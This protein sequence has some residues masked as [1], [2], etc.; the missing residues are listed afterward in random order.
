MAQTITAYTAVLT[1]TDYVFDSPDTSSSKTQYSVGTDLR[2]PADYASRESNGFYP[3]TSP[4][5]GWVRYYL[6]GSI[7]P[8]YTTTTDKCKAPTSVTLNVSSKTLSISGGAGGDLNN[9]T[10]YGVS[11]RD[12]KIGTSSY[13]SWSSD[14]VVTGGTTAT[15][16]VSAPSGYVRQFRVRSLG[17]AGA[18]YYSDYV[19]CSA[20]LSGNTAPNA[21]TVIFPGNGKN[22]YSKTPVVKLNCASDPQG[23]EMTLYRNVDGAGWAIVQKL[24]SG[25]AFDH[26]P[27]V[28]VGSHSVKYKLADSYGLESGETTVSFTVLAL[29]W[30]RV[31]QTGTVIS[32]ASVSHQ[33]DINQLLTVT[34]AQCGW[35]GNSSVA[36]GGTVG[37]FS[38]WKAQMEQLESAIK[39]NAEKA[40]RGVT[41]QSPPSYPTASVI[42]EIRSQL[43]AF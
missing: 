21:P 39:A 31:I 24:N 4:E 12:A 23:D 38:D 41:F 36:L 29:E 28:G 16:A 32:N 33:A 37:R 20:T 10:G 14:V 19:I 18:A 26:L 13:G 22:T 3:V 15:Y 42:N 27:S 9:F 35:C 1:S 8:V 43:E 6:V 34:N 5:S 7:K 2:L 25:Y 40:G 11:W 30:T 17:S